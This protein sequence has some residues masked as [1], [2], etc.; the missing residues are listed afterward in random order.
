MLNLSGRGAPHTTLRRIRGSFM[1]DIP[2]G[3]ER[4][5]PRA[6]RI[7]LAVCA[8]L[9]LFFVGVTLSPLA[10]GFADSREPRPSDLVLYRAEMERIEAGQ[11][12]YD[13][14]AAE[15][16]SRGYPTQSVFN[17]R[18]PLLISSLG[19]LPNPAIARALLAALA[20]FTL[21]LA[22]HCL[23]RDGQ[24]GRALLCG[25]LLVGGLLPCALAGLY[26]TH[27]LWAGVLI[28]L[29]ISAYALK[30]PGWGLAAGVAALAIRELA[31]PYCVLCFVFA[32]AQRRRGEAIAWLFAAAGYA[33][34]FA[35]H[36]A[37]VRADTLPGVA[38]DAGHWFRFGGAGFVISLAQMN[39]VLLLLPQWITA[40]YLALALLGFAG[41][42]S[43]WGKRA[44][45]TAIL[46]LGVFAIVG[47][48][49]NQ[50]WGSLLAPVL[51]L[52]AAQA[53]SALATLWRTAFHVA[54]PVGAEC[55]VRA[56]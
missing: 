18:T 24:T 2:S 26:V 34:A 28:L 20:G 41:W 23:A 53:P 12:Y 39:G 43:N 14:A 4:L 1:A 15:L 42:Q 31:A 16:T 54:E 46:Y 13:A 50:Y 17:W 19:R 55:R 10:S 44:A 45:W 36:V 47:Q 40:I 33:V 56:T 3:F 9:A 49:V 11:S 29:S 8:A 37:A 30:R 32:V 48:P 27:E 35:F 6:A 52:G 51:C 5:S 21:L 7:V 25:L 38:M 22:V